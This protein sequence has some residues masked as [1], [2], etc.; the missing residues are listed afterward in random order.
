MKIIIFLLASIFLLIV[1]FV[2]NRK[3]M[4]R[5]DTNNSLLVDVR[6][7]DEFAEFSDKRSINIPLSEIEA[8]NFSVIQNSDKENIVLV[9]RSGARAQRALDI[10][11]N[12]F[13]NKNFI[14]LNSWQNL[15]SIN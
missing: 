9:C 8:G 7:K 6:T 14:N 2:Y 10:L 3:H 13:P 4:P 1:I 15:S 11:K 12:K 5:F